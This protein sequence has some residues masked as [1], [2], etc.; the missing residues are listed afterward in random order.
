VGRVDFANLPAFSNN[1]RPGVPP[2]TETD[3]LKQYINKD[4]RYRQKQLILNERL[5]VQAALDPAV[6]D[7]EIERTYATALR[8]G[9]RFFGIEPGKVVQGDPFLPANSASL[10]GVAVGYGGYNIINV[11][12]NFG[13]PH[14]T[15]DLAD[16]AMEPPIGFYLLGGS[17]FGDWNTSDNLMRACLATPNYG[18]SCAFCYQV[19]WAFEKMAMDEPL[20][21]GFLRTIELSPTSAARTH[22]AVLGDPTLRLKI[23]AP[24]SN[25]RSSGVQTNVALSWNPSP[26]SGAQ[27]LVYRSL[28]GLK[29]WTRLT[30]NPI[31]A[32]SFTDNPAPA[33][34]KTYMIRAASLSVTGSGSF[35]NL[36]QGIFLNVN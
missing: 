16:P 36:S 35:T 25:P 15:F 14:T 9:N 1:L 10:W 27:Y 7:S 23:I 11:P 17:Y 33:R 32:T 4:N 24:A 29:S 6:L 26:E 21:S 12:L 30:T 5:I 31:S 3:L 19:D 2:K 13:T 8:N 18:L 28:E 34:L 20:G 22:L